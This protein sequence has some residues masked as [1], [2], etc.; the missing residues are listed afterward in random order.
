MSSL[1]IQTK[2]SLDWRRRLDLYP[3]PAPS[4]FPLLSDLTFPILKYFQVFFS[5][6]D[7]FAF[8]FLVEV[9]ICYSY[10]Q[11]LLNFNY[12]RRGNFCF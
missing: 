1:K 11:Y 10:A 8:L 4:N 12:I 6:D 5:Y 2:A 3:P 9:N 7:F